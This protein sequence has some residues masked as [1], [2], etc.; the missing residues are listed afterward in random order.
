MYTAIL[1][2]CVCCSLGLNDKHRLGFDQF[3]GSLILDRDT[4]TTVDPRWSLL[5]ME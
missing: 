1:F 4:V 3:I 2:G 5:H